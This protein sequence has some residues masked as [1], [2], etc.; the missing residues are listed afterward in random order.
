MRLKRM[1]VCRSLVEAASRSIEEVSEDQFS[2]ASPSRWGFSL[3]GSLSIMTLARRSES[4][5]LCLVTPLVLS[6]TVRAP[7]ISQRFVRH[8]ERGS[9]E[10]HWSE[11]S[12]QGY[13]QKRCCFRCW[14]LGTGGQCRKLIFFFFWC[15]DWYILLMYRLQRWKKLI[16]R[17]V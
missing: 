17:I 12:D 11:G 2:L 4:K 15:D 3:R 6:W 5:C 13:R 7:L 1:V 9:K 16:I 8:R 14:I 10:R